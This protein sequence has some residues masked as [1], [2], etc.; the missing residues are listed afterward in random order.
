M[1]NILLC[2]NRQVPPEAGPQGKFL[3]E[4]LGV[5][6]LVNKKARASLSV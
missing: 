6:Y 3:H 1:E 4:K 2:F 5:I